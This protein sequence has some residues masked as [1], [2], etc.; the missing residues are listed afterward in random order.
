MELRFKPQGDAALLAYLG[1]EIDL[2]VNKRVRALADGLRENLHPGVLEVAGSY[3]CLQINLDPLRCTQAELEDWVREQYA[4]LPAELEETGRVVEIP[5]VY[6]GEAGPDL[7]SVAQAVGLSPQEVIERHSSRDYPCYVVGFTPGFPYLGGGDEALSL[8]RLDTR[9][10]RCRWDRW[11][12]PSPRPGSTA[13]A[14]PGDG[15]FWAAPRSVFMIPQRSRPTGS[16]PG[17]WFVS[18]L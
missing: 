8:P 14:D 4:A 5:V 10:L 13:W 18:C 12:W 11:P 2:E 3:A 17:T 9:G 16:A 6:G 1:W 7:E 15:G